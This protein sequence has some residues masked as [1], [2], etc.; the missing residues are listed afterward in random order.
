MHLG[1]EWLN[2]NQEWVPSTL[3]ARSGIFVLTIPHVHRHAGDHADRQGPNGG[4]TKW[5]T[6]DATEATQGVKTSWYSS[7]QYCI[8]IIYLYI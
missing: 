3:K 6:G 7:Q 5:A 4:E 8:Y 2:D 1:W